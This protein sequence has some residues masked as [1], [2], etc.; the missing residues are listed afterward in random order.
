M[1]KFNSRLFVRLPPLV[2]YRLE[3]VAHPLVGEPLYIYISLGNIPLTMHAMIHGRMRRRKRGPLPAMDVRVGKYIEK[4]FATLN[5]MNINYRMKLYVLAR[6]LYNTVL[7][8]FLYVL[9]FMNPGIILIMQ[10]VQQVMAVAARTGE[11]VGISMACTAFLEIADTMVSS[12][13][14][15]I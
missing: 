1:Y 14:S 15:D 13:M 5:R 3:C 11:I 7:Y 8:P 9:D 6:M 4:H 12:C 10:V 2:G